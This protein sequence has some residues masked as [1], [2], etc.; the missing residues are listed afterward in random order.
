MA[1]GF[2]IPL[3]LDSGGDLVTRRRSSDICCVYPWHVSYNRV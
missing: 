2:D 1:N 3:R